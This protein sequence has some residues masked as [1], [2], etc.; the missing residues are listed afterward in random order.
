MTDVPTEHQE[1]PKGRKEQEVADSSSS[2]EETSTDSEMELIDV[3]T[4]FS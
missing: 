1:E 4:I 3:C 2:S